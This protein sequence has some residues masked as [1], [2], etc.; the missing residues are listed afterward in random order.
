MENDK[1]VLDDIL[2]TV[3]FIKDN[4]VTKEEFRKEIAI[5]KS[6]MPTKNFVTE[7]LSDLQGNMVVLMRKEDTKMKT[8]VEILTEKKVLSNDDKKRIFALEPFPELSI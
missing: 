2:E 5:I 6:T 8:L 3:N 7:K 1:Q 4:S